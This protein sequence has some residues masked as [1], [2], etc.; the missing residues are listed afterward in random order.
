MNN[1][2]PNQHDEGAE[3]SL[4]GALILD[5][6]QIESVQGVVR[7]PEDFYLAKHQAAYR[8]LVGLREDG[9]P[10]DLVTLPDALTKLGVLDD[11]GGVPYLVQ[12]AESVPSATSAPY[13]AGIVRDYAL[14]RELIGSLTDILRTAASTYDDI[15]THIERAQEAV[16]A[17]SAHRRETPRQISELVRHVYD[18]VEREHDNPKAH[19]LDTGFCELD[20]MLGGLRPGQ[21][22]I[23]A[24]RTSMG[25][26]ALAMN[27]LTNIADGGVPTAFLSLEM[28]GASVAERVLAGDSRVPIHV[29][30]RPYQ[31]MTRFDKLIGGVSKSADRPLWVVD[32][33]GASMRQVA[34]LSRRLV[35]ERRC[36]VIGIDYLQLINQHEG[37]SQ[38]DMV[39]KT[40]KDCKALARTLDAT[41][42]LLS[43]LSR[44]AT[45]GGKV[46]DPPGVQHLRDSGVIEEAADVVMLLHR[47]DYYRQ[48]TDPGHI[49]NG[50][51][52]LDIQKQREGP[53]GNT[54]LRFEPPYTKFTDYGDAL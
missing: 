30:R 25:K 12:L 51:A 7:G 54:V 11:V 23:L 31:Q 15:D 39:T 35:R 42:L 21:L 29:I 17:L 8:A 9:A 38:Y 40:V 4:L 41:L 19:G 18:R 34:S 6:N 52:T 13:Y 37:R 32:C 16:L 10:V 3:M 2:T 53:T 49:P 33:P 45:D 24:A 27:V 1:V 5:A 26:S 48:R 20:S 50:Q 14:R 43:Q 44:R 36:K 46:P 28:T 47:E 22:V